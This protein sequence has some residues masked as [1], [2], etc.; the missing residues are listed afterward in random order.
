M[1]KFLIVLFVVFMANFGCKK[2]A[3]T[4]RLCACSPTVYPQLF[5]VVKSPNGAD[6]LNPA[7]SGSFTSS[8]IKLYQKES[9]GSL[10]QI[11]FGIRPSFSYGNEKFDYYQLISAELMALAKSIDQSF[12]LK[13][14][15]HAPLEINLA[16]DHTDYKIE[17][18]LVNKVELPVET[19]PVSAYLK[20]I[21]YI[22]L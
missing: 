16:I 6:L 7:V 20:N 21:Y 17:K 19:G 1:R 12:Y 10:K 15:D 8:Q 13:V 18:L 4:E 5:L 2:V 3:E 11:G 14:G 9:N 22:V